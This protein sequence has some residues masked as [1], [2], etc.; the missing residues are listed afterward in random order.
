MIPH[1]EGAKAGHKQTSLELKGVGSLIQGEHL[2]RERST[3]TM[4]P[5]PL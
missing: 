3:N 2:Y 4:Q 1:N 5:N